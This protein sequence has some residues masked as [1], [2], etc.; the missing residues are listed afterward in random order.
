MKIY[1]SASTHGFYPDG[2]SYGDKLP[3][4]VVEIS[5]DD[6]RNLLDGQAGGSSIVANVDGYPVLENHLLSNDE[7]S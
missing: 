3:S 5:E 7:S 4:D 1:Y 2:D 6:Y